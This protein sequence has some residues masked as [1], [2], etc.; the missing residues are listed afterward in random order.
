MSNLFETVKASVSVREAAERYGLK[1]GRNAMTC[2]PFHD[3]RHPSMKLNQDFYYCFG[4]GATGDVI[5][6]VSQ[7]FDLSPY[8]AA[9]K[10]AEDFGIDPDK[11]P[12][13]AALAKPK[14]PMINAIR[15]DERYCHRVL[16]DYLH[17][18][19]DWKVQ[20]A[21]TSM[22]EDPDDRFVEACQMLDYVKCLADILAFGNP[23]DRVVTVK[24]LMKD[25]M[26]TGLEARLDRAKEE[27]HAKEE[28][29]AG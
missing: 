5:D 20:Y 21:P 1:V 3:D 12:T 13:A 16:W 26:I 18:L 9:K 27:D 23:E 25:G 6:L 7:L 15:D 11:P 2:C 14:H 10:I 4:C 24:T 28:S 17:L 19:T 22:D 8:E 29:A